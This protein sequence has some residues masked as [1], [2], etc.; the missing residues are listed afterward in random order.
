MFQVAAMTDVPSDVVQLQKDVVKQ[1]ERLIVAE[2]DWQRKFLRLS[3]NVTLQVS[4]VS[5]MQVL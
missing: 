1:G 5:K 4:T 3:D 2:D